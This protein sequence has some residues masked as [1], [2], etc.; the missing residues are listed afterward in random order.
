MTMH[1][2]TKEPVSR[3]H[4]GVGGTRVAKPLDLRRS[5]FARSIRKL[6]LK[7]P[8]SWIRLSSPAV[9]RAKGPSLLGRHI[10][11]PIIDAKSPQTRDP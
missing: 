1:G 3:G 6:A 8:C 11:L 5:I 7:F 10:P 2:S 9:M 4:G